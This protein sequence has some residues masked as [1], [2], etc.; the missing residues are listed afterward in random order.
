MKDAGSLSVS[1]CVV[2][3]VD[4]RCWDGYSRKKDSRMIT[5]VAQMMLVSMPVSFCVMTTVERKMLEWLQ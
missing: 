5:A 2:I 3:T 1:F 4:R